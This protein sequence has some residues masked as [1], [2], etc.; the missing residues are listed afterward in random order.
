IKRLD[1]GDVSSR[2]E[3]RKNLTCITF[4]QY[5]ERFQLKNFPSSYRWIG[6]VANIDHRC[7]DSMLGPDIS[8][9]VRGFVSAQT[10]HMDGGN[11]VFMYTTTKKLQFDELCLEPNDQQTT[12]KQRRILFIICEEYRQEQNWNYNEETNQLVHEKTNHCLDVIKDTIVVLG[13]NEHVL[14]MN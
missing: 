3:L 4:R 6:T 14:Q 10:C 8:K 7:L 1:G 13:K 12:D 2:I 5:L 9:G 11:Q